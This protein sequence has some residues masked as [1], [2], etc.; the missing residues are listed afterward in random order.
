MTIK[1][2][3]PSELQ[4]WVESKVASG[5]YVDEADVIRAALRNMQDPWAELKEFLQPRIDQANRGEFAEQ[6]FDEIIAEAR[7][8][9]DAAL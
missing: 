2:T 7:Q 6:S 9:Y 5:L 3:L 8:D 4:K 1:L